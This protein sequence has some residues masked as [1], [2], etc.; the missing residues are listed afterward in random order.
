M[1]GNPRAKRTAALAERRAE[2]WRMR[3]NGQTQQEIGDH[4]GISQQAVSE[5]LRKAYTDRPAAAIDEYRAIELDK[6]DRAERAVLA[7]M[8]RQHVTVSGGS[9][10]MTPDSTGEMVPLLDDAPVLAAVDRL[11]KIAKHRADLLG[12]KAPTKISVEAESLGQE[13]A[14]LLGQLGTGDDNS[15]D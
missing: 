13:I 7:V 11:V 4:Y 6:L 15:D 8:T 14:E 2:M 5:Q 10:V 9:I 12:L 1:A 3:V